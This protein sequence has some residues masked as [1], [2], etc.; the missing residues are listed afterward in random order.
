MAVEKARNI[1]AWRQT[2]V[3]FFGIARMG[4]SKAKKPEHL[5]KLEGDQVIKGEVGAMSKE[6]K[7]EYV[8]KRR[9]QLQAYLDNQK[10]KQ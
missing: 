10:S 7:R 4:G 3:I 5:M 9:A 6:E 8:K 2:R 1:E